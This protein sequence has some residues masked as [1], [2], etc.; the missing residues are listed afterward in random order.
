MRL[1]YLAAVFG[2]STLLIASC[3][4]YESVTLMPI[5]TDSELALEYYET[6]V[7]EFDQLKWGMARENF[8]MSVKEDPDIFMSY[9]WMY[10]MSH[11]S[12]KKIAEKALQC[13]AD[14]NDAEKQIEIAFKYLVD[15]Q[16]E[17]VVE[18]MM[19]AIDLYPSD[20]YLYKILYF[21]QSQF[22]KDMEG[23]LETIGQAIKFQ[24]D[25]AS[26][27]NYKGYAHMDMDEFGKAEAAFDNY[28]K[29]A[30][31]TANPYD[32]K[33][34]YFMATKQFKDA[35]DSY[36]KAFEMDSDFYVSEKKAKKAMQLM[37]KSME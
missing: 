24:P 12:S 9:V 17:K 2:I 3:T 33:G 8:E 11:K 35:F 10:F 26:A 6:G 20:P 25:Y 27:Y 1:S 18:H 22:F 37:E 13:D 32:S 31:N 36:M 7:L 4:Y 28:I 23:S 15:G 14:L 19:S 29:L 34:D 16:E 5:T 30:P 21:I